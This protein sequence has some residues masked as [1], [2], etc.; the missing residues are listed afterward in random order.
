MTHHYTREDLL[1]AIEGVGIRAGD[2]VSLQVSLGRLGLPLGVEQNYAALSNFVIDAFLDVL[3]PEG[4]LV[5]PTYTY[6]I[7]RGTVFEVETTPSSI[8]EFPEVF[9]A[10]KGVVRSRDPMMSSAGIGPASAVVLRDLSHSCYGDGSSFHRLRDADAKICTLGISLYWATFRHHIEEMA[11]VPFRFP[12]LFTG[13]VRERG[14]DASETWSYFAAPMVECC[15]P[16]GLP[17]E[18][19]ARERGLVEVAPVGRGEI[20]AIG[21]RKYFEFGLAELQENP[22]LTAKGPPAAREVIFKNEPQWIAAQSVK[23]LLA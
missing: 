10:R 11:K 8:G 5:V 4:T 6:S 1:R 3:G 9:R 16:N 23:G 17:L 22:W 20:M 14:I 19:R 13:T 12:K 2:I 7:G 21:A 15:T 18:K